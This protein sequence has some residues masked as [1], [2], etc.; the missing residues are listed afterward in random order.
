MK[1]ATI[2]LPVL[3]E[4]ILTESRKINFPMLSDLYTGSF[5][6]TLVSSKPTG[7]FLELGTGTGLSLAWIVEGMTNRS[8]I[9]SIDNDQ[10]CQS[11]ARHMFGS[12]P[13]V[14]LICT[15]GNEWIMENIEERFDFIFADAWPG[16]YS[17]LD[18][19]LSMLNPGGF[20][21]IDDMLPQPNWPDGHQE[22]VDNLISELQKYSNLQI[23][24]INWSTGL[25]LV[26]KI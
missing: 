10:Y 15:D 1:N 8:S 19:T 4:E 9:V 6:R 18:E 13:R 11:V 7:R 20:Y 22:I 25:I 3:Y 23:T 14:S 21:L 26:S 2:K 16:K 17:L 12:D 24:V 5:L